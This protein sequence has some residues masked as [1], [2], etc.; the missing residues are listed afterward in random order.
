MHVDNKGM[1]D[2]IGIRDGEVEH[3]K[4]HRTKDGEEIYVAS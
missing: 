3:V 1:I 2:N 4:A